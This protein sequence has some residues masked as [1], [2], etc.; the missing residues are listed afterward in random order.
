[1]LFLAF[2][3]TIVLPVIV[4]IVLIILAEKNDWAFG[5]LVPAI[6]ALA[7]MAAGVFIVVAYAENMPE[8]QSQSFSQPQ[9]VAGSQDDYQPIILT[10]L[11]SG[12]GSWLILI[13]LVL[14]LGPKIRKMNPEGNRH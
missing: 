2:L 4:F 12:G 9:F 3:L 8:T 13:L 5:C 1:M 11:C 7:V 6:V 14:V 10:N